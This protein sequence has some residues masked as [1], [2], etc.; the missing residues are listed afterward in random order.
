MISTQTGSTP[1][2]PPHRWGS[3]QPLQ[4]NIMDSGGNLFYKIVL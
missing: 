4:M 3:E 2:I 1:T